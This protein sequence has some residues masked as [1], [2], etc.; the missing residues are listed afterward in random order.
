MNKTIRLYSIIFILAIGALY[1]YEYAK[2]KPI[3]WYPSFAKK[4]KIPFGTYILHDALPDL[5]PNAE[6]K[7]THLP[8]YEFLD[9]E[10]IEA[11]LFFVN[12]DIEFDEA[13]MGKMLNFVAKGNTVFASGNSL[14]IDTLNIKSK[15]LFKDGVDDQLIYKFYSPSFK[16]REY[17]F[18]AKL[19]PY[20]FQSIDTSNTK[21]LGLSAYVSKNGERTASGPNFIE[22]KFGKGK[23]LLHNAPEVFTNYGI[24]EKPIDQYAAGVLSYLADAKNL[25]WD[26]YHKSGKSSISSPM[27]YILTNRS[28]KWAYF[29]M[30]FGFLFYVI[31]EGKR[32]QRSIPVIKALKN[33]SLAFARTI[34]N[35]YYEKQDHLSIAQHQIRFFLDYIRTTY[36]L[37]TNLFN[38]QFYQDLTARSG[39]EL[40]DIE[41]LFTLIQDLQQK[42]SITADE[43]E[44]LN[45][46][47]E[48][49]KQ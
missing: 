27:H 5:F 48:K 37:E 49:F 38:D 12:D 11:S 4:H 16:N 17:A 8:T 19:N 33:Q 32:K 22:V 46:Q 28:L 15:R 39:K 41:K 42:G 20:I 23:F 21:I 47:I 10:S 31:F 36:R 7:E 34:G 44:K 2:P 43:L 35:M 6:L 14:T 30:L 9:D 25:I 1:L 26:T 24:L 3:N 45:R 40:A 18:K 13:T 29:I